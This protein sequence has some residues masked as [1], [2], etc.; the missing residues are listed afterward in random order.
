MQVAAS[1][2]WACCIADIKKPSYRFDDNKSAAKLIVNFLPTSL[3]KVV[4]A[5]SGYVPNISLNFHY[6]LS[7]KILRSSSDN[8]FN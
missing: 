3:M 1:L 8:Y 2:L 5:I 6:V 7:T 4:G